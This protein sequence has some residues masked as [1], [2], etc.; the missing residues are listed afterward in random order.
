ML[1][2]RKLELEHQRYLA[3]LQVEERQRER[4]HELKK[5]QTQKEEQEAKLE[6]AR[7][8]LQRLEEARAAQK[9]EA[10]TQEPV[11]ASKGSS[12][13]VNEDPNVSLKKELRDDFALLVSELLDGDESEWSVGEVRDLLDA[14]KEWQR[15]VK[16]WAQRRA[17]A[18]L[19]LPQWKVSK[20]MKELLDEM[21]SES[22][23][24]GFFDNKDVYLDLDPEWAE[25]LE[26][27][28][29]E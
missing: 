12:P 22:S 15:Q 21:L 25:E 29:D 1:K 26:Q 8:Q 13:K 17:M 18:Y 2:S 3:Q 23:R 19:D 4:D 7:L 28:L 27:Y 11:K 6:A 9:S 10:P 14:I 20:D 16:Q 24:R 5:L